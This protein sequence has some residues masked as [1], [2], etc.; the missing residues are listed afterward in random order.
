MVQ[1]ELEPGELKAMAERMQ[2]DRDAV[3]AE[4]LRRQ[5]AATLAMLQQEA[6]EVRCPPLPPLLLSP[7]G[8]QTCLLFVCVLAGTCAGRCG[9][10]GCSGSPSG[11][12]AR[13]CAVGSEA[14]RRAA[15]QGGQ[16]AQ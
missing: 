9:S 7:V 14:G 10:T 4:E 8:I 3:R 6:K 2:R 13:G 11:T 1:V 16:V 12:A 5:E 15:S